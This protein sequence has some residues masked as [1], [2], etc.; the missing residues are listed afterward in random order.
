M[1]SAHPWLVWSWCYAHRLELACKNA[2]TSTLFKGIEEMLLRLYFLYEKSPKKTRELEGIVEDLKEVF[3][4]PKGGNKPVR[5]QGSRWINHKRKALPSVVDRYGVYINH[6][7]TLAE[8]KSLKADDRVRLKGYLKKWTQ[9]RI[10]LGS[11][12]YIDIL[13]PPSILSLSLQESELDIVLGM[14]N[15][16]KSATAL[17]S[18]ASQSPFEWPTVKSLLGKIKDEG[19]KKSYQGAELKGYSTATQEK[20]GK[21][22]L[23][24]LTRLNENMRERLKWSDTKLLRSLLVFLETQSWAKQSTRGRHLVAD[25]YS[26]DDIQIE[27]D[28]SLVEVQACVDHIATHFR[29]PLEAK[30]VSIATLQDE[31][32]EAVEYARTYL[33][34]DRTKY[35]KV[36]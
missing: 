36:W 32:E 2:L 28:C 25:S 18:L 9:Y 21:D 14:K 35:H 12:M 7:A 31:V 10:L 16:L 13:K 22:A 33:D 8:D 1:Q 4:L 6:L 30:G 23:G 20:A 24:D 34:I 15:I 29:L 26:E 27:E 17:K 3:E 5:S 11:A 19:R